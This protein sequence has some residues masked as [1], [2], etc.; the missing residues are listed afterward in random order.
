MIHII[1]ANGRIGSAIRSS[2]NP[3]SLNLLSR[4][5]YQNWWKDDSVEDIRHF[6]STYQS[7]KTS[8]LIAA[9][10]LDPKMSKDEHLKTNFLLPRNI[11][12]ATAD[13]GIRVMTFGTIS[14][15][16]QSEANSYI[17]SK[18]MLSDYILTNSDLTKMTIHVRLHTL[19]GG[20]EPNHFMFLGQIYD[21][22]TMGQQMSMTSG[23]QLRE[24]HHVDDDVS[25]IW[26]I[27]DSDFVGAIDLNHGSPITLRNLAEYL[28]RRFDC[29]SLLNLGSL[30]EPNAENYENVFRPHSLYENIDF[31]LSLPAIG[32]YIRDSLERRAK[33]I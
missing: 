18:K 31:R 15:H 8:V 12:A 3:R 1:G 20:S 25:A 33:L 16:F 9:G 5:D 32:D 14:E 17:R 22:L 24:Y 19:Y 13:L 23:R 10:I 2:S 29:E 28:F 27:L 30:P 7:S 11:I 21:S 26:K 6:F 4:S